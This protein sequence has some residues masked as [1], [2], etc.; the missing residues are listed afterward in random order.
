MKML[1]AKKVGVELI[2]TNDKGFVG[3]N[4]EV[5]GTE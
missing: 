2:V 3:L 5:R 4:I 1:C